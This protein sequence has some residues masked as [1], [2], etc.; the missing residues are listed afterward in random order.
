VRLGTTSVDTW[1]IC[2]CGECVTIC[3]SVAARSGADLQRVWGLQIP[4]S[5]IVRGPDNQEP[6]AELATDVLATLETSA[7]PCI[8]TV[9]MVGCSCPNVAAA[10]AAPAVGVAAACQVFR[11]PARLA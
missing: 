7:L 9:V 6:L 4:S 1:C 3:T 2:V 5:V 11:T 8:G 10:A